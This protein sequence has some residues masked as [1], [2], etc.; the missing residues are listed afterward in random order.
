MKDLAPNTRFWLWN[1]KLE[2]IQVEKQG[3]DSKINKKLPAQRNWLVCITYSRAFTVSWILYHSVPD[4]QDYSNI[5]RQKRVITIFLTANSS[6][7]CMRLTK[8]LF[9][10][11]I[12]VSFSSFLQP[13]PHLS[14]SE[15]SVISKL[16]PTHSDGAS[17]TK[18]RA[19]LSRYKKGMIKELASLI[20]LW[21]ILQFYFR[22]HNNQGLYSWRNSPNR[23]SQKEL[24]FFHQFEKNKQPFFRSSLNVFG[25]ITHFE[26]GNN[27][28]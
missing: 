1:R 24:I 27:A 14:V 17:F 6:Q 18:N 11:Y 23:L 9:D 21:R 8:V 13:F 19:C 20:T 28:F 26:L 16:L 25:N 22:T 2:S 5:P 12:L 4:G 3:Q 15:E 10:L 7:T